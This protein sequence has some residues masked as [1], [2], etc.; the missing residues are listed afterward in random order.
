[1]RTLCLATAVCSAALCYA[2]QG[3]GRNLVENGGFELSADGS[4]RGWSFTNGFN[5]CARVV[6]GAGCDGSS[7]VVFESWSPGARYTGTPQQW[8]DVEPGVRYR[9]ESRIRIDGF[10]KGDA[11]GGARILMNLYDAAGRKVGL[12]L[13]DGIVGNTQG[14]VTFAF[15]SPPIQR[16]VVRI[17]VAPWID[18]PCADGR[19]YYDELRVRLS[20][21]LHAVSASGYRNQ[22]AGGKVLLLAAMGFSEK[23]LSRLKPQGRFT[24]VENATGRK[25][26]DSEP[27]SVRPTVAAL[28]VDTSSWCPGKYTVEF[29]LSYEGGDERASLEYERVVELPKRRMFIDSRKKLVKDGKK[30]FPLGL[31]AFSDMSY[32]DIRLVADAGFNCLMPYGQFDGKRMDLCAKNGIGVIYSGISEEQIRAVKDHPALFAWYLYD[33]AP[34]DM[35]PRLRERYELVKRL[36][37]DHPAWCANNEHSAISSYLGTFDA[38]GSDPYPVNHPSWSMGPYVYEWMDNTRKET[39]GT[40]PIWQVVQIF[41]KAAY[42]QNLLRKDPA[43]GMPVKWRPPSYEEMRF[44]T[45]LP[46]SMG[47]NGIIYY[48]FFDLRKMESSDPFGGRWDEIRRIAA[49]IGRY[50][51]LILDGEERGIRGI[52]FRM[53]ARVWFKDGAWWLLAVNA[54]QKPQTLV[55]PAFG[56]PDGAGGRV[57]EILFGN[58]GISERDQSLSLEIPAEHPV[59]LKLKW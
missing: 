58:V 37:P 38:I 51:D 46:I 17:R 57:A 23:L 12:F 1:M 28:V 56:R 14:W 45:W 4:L 49:E 10:E 33:E 50:K 18:G 47:A 35:I 25:V 3:V 59:L 9:I 48:S 54:D 30:V 20:P 22:S 55:V 44:M 34:M 21:F 2:A 32:D 36:D 19:V 8:I 27:D 41:N 42:K 6:S 40:K 15:D 31:Y 24:V 5:G 53:G 39:F 7:G 26:V 52:P 29:A 11:F 43:T 16:D 13:K